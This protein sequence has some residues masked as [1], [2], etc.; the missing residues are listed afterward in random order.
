MELYYETKVV[1]ATQDF[2]YR[3]A[4]R[5]V[6]SQDRMLIHCREGQEHCDY[7]VF[8]F[9]PGI[10]YPS[11][12]IWITI[13]NQHL[14][15]SE[16]EKITFDVMTH[17]RGYVIA[18]LLVRY[19]FVIASFAMLF[20]YVSFYIKM[21]KETAT[22]EHKA[23]LAL[24]IALVLF[25]D[26]FYGLTLLMP[27]WF[28][29]SVS[30]LYVVIFICG[31]IFFWMIMFQRI[32]KEPLLIQT[33]L[34]KP[35]PM[36]LTLIIFLML[37]ITEYETTIIRRF[38]PGANVYEEYFNQTPE[39]LPFLRRD[40]L[41]CC[42]VFVLLVWVQH[43]H[44]RPALERGHQQTPDLLLFQ[45]LLRPFLRTHDNNWCRQFIQ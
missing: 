8:L 23:I 13:L 1:P 29:V 33:N 37:L 12:F 21:P 40:D 41:R 38:D 32:Y 30:L 36:A 19:S 11:Y 10:H 2:S 24:S 27:G 22:F 26:P 39:T 31:L 4:D 28:S 43:F 25:N 20:S 15:A 35:W 17:S 7:R 45:S 18:F 34:I 9:Y 6:V 3:Y 16:I 5:E 44:N 14:Y 42:R